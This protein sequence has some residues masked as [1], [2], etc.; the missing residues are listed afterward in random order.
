M[1]PVSLLRPQRDYQLHQRFLPVARTVGYY[2]YLGMVSRKK[3]Q[4]IKNK[5]IYVITGDTEHPAASRQRLWMN[6]QQQFLKRYPSAKHNRA[7]GVLYEQQEV[8]QQKV[9]LRVISGISNRE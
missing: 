9:L 2:E 7:N 1:N 6:Q 3:S 8:D 4:A 5:A